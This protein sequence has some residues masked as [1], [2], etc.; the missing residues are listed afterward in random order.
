MFKIIYHFKNIKK[1]CSLGFNII[2]IIKYIT[3][4]LEKKNIALKNISKIKEFK[5][6]YKNGSYSFDWITGNSHNFL[7]IKKFFE[8]R[9]IE[10]KINMMSNHKN[11]LA[12]LRILE[13]GS[14]EGYS[15]NLFNKIFFNPEIYCVDPWMT[16]SEHPSLNFKKIEKN[17]DKNTKKINVK[18]FKMSSFDFFKK[19]NKNYDLIYID[20]SHKADDVFYDAMKSFKILKKGGILFFDDFLGATIFDNKQVIDG[21]ALFL[22]KINSN[23]LKLIFINSQIGF[24]KL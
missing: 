11:Y 13:I 1:F 24:L 23:N 9:N 19:N 21:V 16:Y 5:K 22:N 7:I 14:F 3:G 6:I 12:N 20:G 10:S 17:F 8:S 15:A 18:K 4:I 2:F